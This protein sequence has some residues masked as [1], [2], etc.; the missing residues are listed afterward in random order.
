M[1]LVTSTKRTLPELH[2]H[3]GAGIETGWTASYCFTYM[4]KKMRRSVWK[5]DVPQQRLLDVISGASR[6]PT[7]ACCSKRPIK[8]TVSNRPR[9]CDCTYYFVCLGCV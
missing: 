5:L 7:C 8:A 1:M 2:Q 9:R 3:A 4:V 6:E